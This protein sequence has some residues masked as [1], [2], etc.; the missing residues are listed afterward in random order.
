MRSIERDD[1]AGP[2]EGEGKERKKKKKKENSIIAI[3]ARV[4]KMGHVTARANRLVVTPSALLF[5]S[6]SLGPLS[7]TNN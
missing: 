2:R 6:F 3:R 1:R 7:R 5:L 4:F